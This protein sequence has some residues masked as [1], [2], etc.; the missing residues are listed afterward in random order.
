MIS[1]I[2]PTAASVSPAVT[3][4]NQFITFRCHSVLTPRQY[5][6]WEAKLLTAEAILDVTSRSTMFSE[7][8]EITTA[9]GQA[10][11]NLVSKNIGLI[12]VSPRAGSPR[13]AQAGRDEQGVAIFHR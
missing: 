4:F 8:T 9:A 7:G 5:L 13:E 2:Q 3:G 6:K 10:P 12:P 1:L 11:L